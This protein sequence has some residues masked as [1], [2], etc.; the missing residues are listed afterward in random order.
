MIF[1]HV[2]D[3]IKQ[4]LTSSWLLAVLCVLSVGLM[5]LL[6]V[7]G[8]PLTIKDAKIC[9]GIVDI[10]LSWTVERATFIVEKWSEAG[11]IETA[12]LQTRLDFIFLCAYPAS[13]S[14]AC[15]KLAGSR[16]GF[17]A[18]AGIALSWAVLF[19]IPLDAF[20]NIMILNMLSGN[21]ACPIPILTSIAATLKFVLIAISLLLY[22]P[23]LLVLMVLKKS[24]M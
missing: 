15:R 23:L 14:L 21:Y 5:W 13:L 7:I 19:C 1:P 10:E 16:E 24:M 12:R 3:K 17:M 6:N 9:W 22:I 8:E 20:E 4:V 2:T 18:A 11:L